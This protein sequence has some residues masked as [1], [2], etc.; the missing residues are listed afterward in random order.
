MSDEVI[1]PRYLVDPASAPAPAVAAA[2]PGASAGKGAKAK[3]K[4]DKKKKKKHSKYVL[5]YRFFLRFK[6]LI[7]RRS[8]HSSPGSHEDDMF[9]DSEEEGEKDYRKGFCC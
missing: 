4:R 6:V 3:R 8:K 7:L 5:E 9:E 1:D 2:A